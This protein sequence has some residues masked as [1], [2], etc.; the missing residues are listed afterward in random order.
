MED[1]MRLHDP[2]YTSDGA[3]LTIDDILVAEDTY[4]RAIEFT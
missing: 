1:G 4:S 3:D 2:T